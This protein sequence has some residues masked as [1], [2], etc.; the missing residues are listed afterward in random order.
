MSYN[1]LQW[2]SM[3]YYIFIDDIAI[4]IVTHQTAPFNHC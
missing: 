2:V 1:E 4:L 3:S